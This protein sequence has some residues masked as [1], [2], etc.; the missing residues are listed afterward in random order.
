M[1]DYSHV[2]RDG[3]PQPPPVNGHAAYP[4]PPPPVDEAEQPDDDLPPE[5]GSEPAERGPL[6][7]E[8][9]PRP[10][11]LV[12]RMGNRGPRFPTGFASIDKGWRGGAMM[13]K[14]WGLLGAPGAG[15]TTMAL[16]LAY[17]FALQGI[18]GTTLR[19]IA[20]ASAATPSI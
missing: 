13:G 9:W 5:I 17:S 19:D 6:K 4:P 7:A 15:K 8:L 2:R 18:A 20:A 3:S 11:S 16:Q 14:R 1:I 10:E 12:A